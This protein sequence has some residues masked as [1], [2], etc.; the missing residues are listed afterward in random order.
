MAGG[1]GSCNRCNSNLIIAVLNASRTSDMRCRNHGEIWLVLKRSG[2]GPG[3]SG[4]EECTRSLSVVPK[5]DT[6][7]GDCGDPMM[8]VVE[9]RFG[10][11]G[12]VEWR[13]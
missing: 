9:A 13:R 5:D 7:V 3:I 2:I 10:L 1:Y 11:G 6:G 4:V 8:L 12:G